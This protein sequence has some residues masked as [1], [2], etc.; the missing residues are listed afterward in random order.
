MQE[1]KVILQEF[2]HLFAQWNWKKALRELNKN[3][4]HVWLRI[5]INGLQ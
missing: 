1:I 2:F 3:Y 5:C 4:S